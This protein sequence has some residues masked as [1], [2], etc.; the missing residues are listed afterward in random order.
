MATPQPRIIETRYRDIP[1][2]EIGHGTYT[3]WGPQRGKPLLIEVPAG[4]PPR[5]LH[6]PHCHTGPFFKVVNKKHEIF[7]NN[8]WVCPHIAEI[9]D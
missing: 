3:P 2:E 4:P 7:G 6:P 9:G 8:L 5:W 1:A